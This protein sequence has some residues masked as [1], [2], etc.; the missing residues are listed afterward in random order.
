MLHFKHPSVRNVYKILSFI[1][2]N[3]RHSDIIRDFKKINKNVERIR[4]S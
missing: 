2:F 4:E 3:T 1:L